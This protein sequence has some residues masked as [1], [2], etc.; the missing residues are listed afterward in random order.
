MMH[1]VG[2]GVGHRQQGVHAAPRGVDR[3]QPALPVCAA[4]W[5]PGRRCAAVRQQK[6]ALSLVG[7][8]QEKVWPE[9]GV[10]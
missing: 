2:A 4:E 10:T 1:S 6:H 9:N 5:P 8:T 3:S 7:M